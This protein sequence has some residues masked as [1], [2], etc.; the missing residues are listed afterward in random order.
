MPT[1]TSHLVRQYVTV[2]HNFAP[3]NHGTD[4]EIKDVLYMM[5]NKSSFIPNDCIVK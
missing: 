1:C 4:S 3:C 5:R 2:G